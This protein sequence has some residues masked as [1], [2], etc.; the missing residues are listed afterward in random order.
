LSAEKAAW[1]FNINNYVVRTSPGTLVALVALAIYPDP[2]AS[3][4]GY[5]TLMLA[6]LTAGDLGL[7]VAS[8]RAARVGTTSTPLT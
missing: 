4:L 5:P 8:L 1:V 2:E 3:E 7:A 6:S